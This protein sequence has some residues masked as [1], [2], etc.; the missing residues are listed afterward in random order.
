[1]VMLPV[2][3]MGLLAAH[4]TARYRASAT[5]AARIGGQVPTI[6]ALV[7]LRLALTNEEVAVSTSGWSSRF[8]VAPDVISKLLGYGPETTTAVAG[9]ATDAAL[10]ALGASSPVA[11]GAVK[12]VRAQVG[13]GA[14]GLTAALQTYAGFDA[15]LAAVLGPRLSDLGLAA[16]QVDG[17]NRLA[18]TLGTLRAA[19]D[20]LQY[21][22]AEATDLAEVAISTAGQAAPILVRLGSD[23]TRYAAAAASLA[24]APDAAISGTWKELMSSQDVGVYNQTVT[25]I[26][27]GRA[28]PV[29]TISLVTAFKGAVTRSTRLFGIVTAATERV[30]EAAGSL[31]SSA[32]E[33][34]LGWLTGSA[35]IGLL[36]A[37]VGWALAR[38]ITRPLAKLAESARAVAAGQLADGL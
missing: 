22:A 31:Q 17:G 1:M 7:R 13:A 32:R 25:T 34:Y 21:G 4:D 5:A 2:V 36:M 27:Q 23:S 19:T 12:T 29:D 35:L 10:A 11:A 3:V 8:H 38:S 9:P 16:E 14:I 30:K 15:Q 26:E 28:V 37:V 20:G 6:D 33:T 24:A 18:A